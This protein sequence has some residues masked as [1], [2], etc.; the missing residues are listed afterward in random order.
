MPDGQPT[1][2]IKNILAKAALATVLIL[3]VGFIGGAA[4][5]SSQ[6]N[7]G[8]FEVAPW[9]GERNLEVLAFG[10]GTVTVASIDGDDPDMRR[11]AVMGLA[12]DAG[13]LQM[14]D[15]V[16]DAGSSVVRKA[17]LLAGTAPTVGTLA[18]ADPYAF[19]E[20]PAAAGL[21]VEIVQYESPIGAMD[22]WFVDGNRS[23]WIIHIH[24]KG[25]SPQEAI[26][27]MRPLA[28]A[29]YNQLA[30]T[31]RNDPGQP[32]GPTGVYQYGQTEFE[33]LKGAVQ[34]ALDRNATDVVLVGYST[35]A[36]IATAY[37]F[38]SLVPEVQGAVFDA[39][40]LDMGKTVDF[41]AEQRSLPFGLP[42]PRTM[43]GL[44]KVLT[45]LRLNVNWDNID[46]VRRVGRL[47]IPVVIFHGA[48]DLTVPIDVSREFEGRRSEFVTLVEVADA[49]H[50][51]SWNVDPI[52]YE[53]RVLDFI[54][55]ITR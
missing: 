45:A 39:P 4:Y 27:L 24:G 33:D 54:A 32:P 3:I 44:A 14:G 23:E 51:S 12:Y 34:Y 49:G 6:L 28:A 8:A 26:R 40:N 2:L 50:V 52:A 31:Y 16:E 20:D 22:A 5:Y 36:A 15:V 10:G 30:I 35:G 17:T 53:E 41:A 19:P 11:G 46:Y 21:A 42:V 18:D 7:E 29:G 55:E 38:R 1:S 9:T 13:Y 48:E 37:A 47:T 25:A 43:V